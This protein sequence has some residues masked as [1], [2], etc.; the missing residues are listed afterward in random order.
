MKPFD[1]LKYREAILAD[2]INYKFKEGQPS[3]VKNL[4]ISIDNQTTWIP[5]IDFLHQN[6]W[7]NTMVGDSDKISEAEQDGVISHIIG[8]RWEPQM[9]LFNGELNFEKDRI[10]SRIL[11]QMNESLKNIIYM[12]SAFNKARIQIKREKQIDPA[13]N[14]DSGVAIYR[15]LRYSDVDHEIKGSIA[16]RQFVNT[17]SITST[18]RDKTRFERDVQLTIDS[19][20]DAVP[21]EK[22]ITDPSKRDFIQKNERENFLGVRPKFYVPEDLTKQ[23]NGRGREIHTLHLKQITR[24]INRGF[25]KFQELYKM[26]RA[27]LKTPASREL[28]D[29]N[30]NLQSFL[31]QDPSKILYKDKLTIAYQVVIACSKLSSINLSTFTPEVLLKQFTFNSHTKTVTFESAVMP[32]KSDESQ[33]YEKSNMAYL[34]EMILP[35][36]GI[37]ANLIDRLNAHHQNDTLN[38]VNAI[39]E[40]SLVALAKQIQVWNIMQVK[41]CVESLDFISRIDQAISEYAT[42]LEMESGNFFKKHSQKS[43]DVG[44]TLLSEIQNIGNVDEQKQALAGFL[45]KYKGS[46]NEHSLKVLLVQSVQNAKPTTEN[47]R[48]KLVADFIRSNQ[49]V[50]PEISPDQFQ[51]SR[52]RR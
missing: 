46:F 23:T 10:L 18:T 29:T 49:A 24:D 9:K 30:F 15:G 44:K 38:S 41:P 27:N 33:D 48:K 6:D 26:H 50:S 21:L 34:S 32:Q 25:R 37:Q 45:T 17:A 1:Y 16:Q 19:G 31:T 8:S 43:L 7:D 36:L 14:P 5:M 47:E 4:L 52:P 12:Q 51:M 20:N 42:G 2:Q 28:Q 3:L 11:P 39:N 35:K 13:S 40:I 22:M